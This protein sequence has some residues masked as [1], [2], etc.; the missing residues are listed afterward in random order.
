[1]AGGKSKHG[2][3]DNARV[4]D[5]F[6]PTPWEGTAAFLAREM[7]VLVALGGRVWEC[8]C[9][10]GAMARVMAQCGLNV[11]ATDK[12]ARGY[13]FRSDFLSEPPPGRPW[14]IVTNPPYC[15]RLPERFV[16]HAFGIGAPYIAL[17]LKSN[18]WHAA[19]RQ[20]LRRELP[21]RRA[22]PLGFRLDFLGQAS[23]TMDCTWWV[24]DWRPEIGPHPLYCEEWPACPRP[25]DPA[26]GVML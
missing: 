25:A 4:E 23:P 8:A 19:E 22:H 17:L 13:G 5:D 15:D 9:G 24:W 21:P 12:V 7:D 1:M 26:Q 14:P 11:R 2:Q 3:A 20:G 16:R 10:D 18:Y 6:Y